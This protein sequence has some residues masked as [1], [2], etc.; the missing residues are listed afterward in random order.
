MFAEFWGNSRPPVAFRRGG[1][2]PFLRQWPAPD[3][4]KMTRKDASPKLKFRELSQQA[5]YHRA[6]R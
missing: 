5:F 4:R 6:W 3:W 2:F 1:L